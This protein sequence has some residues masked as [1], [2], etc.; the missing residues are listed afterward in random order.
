MF[1]RRWD[2]SKAQVTHERLEPGDLYP[3]SESKEFLRSGILLPNWGND[4]VVEGAGVL[5]SSH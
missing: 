2:G 1:V 4:G 3:S 5:K